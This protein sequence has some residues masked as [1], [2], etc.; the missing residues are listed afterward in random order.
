MFP[1]FKVQMTQWNRSPVSL[2]LFLSL[3]LLALGTDL[4]KR[5]ELDLEWSGRRRPGSVKKYLNVQTR[6]EIDL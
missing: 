1:E 4:S 5:Q 3:N 6:R 2:S